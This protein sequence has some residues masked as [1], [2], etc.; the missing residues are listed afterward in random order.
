MTK[1]RS[2]TVT[3]YALDNPATALQVLLL[4]LSAIGK[5]I[6]WGKRKWQARS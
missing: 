1:T 3:D 5:L 2:R 4:L 6:I